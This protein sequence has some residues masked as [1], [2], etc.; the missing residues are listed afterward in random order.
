MK[1]DGK[2]VGFF[3]DALFGIQHAISAEHHAK[4]SFSS[5]GK[6]LWMDV[7]KIVREMRS[8]YLYRIVKEGNAQCYCV[9]K[10][11]LAFVQ[12]LKE[13]GDRYT[14]SGEVDLSKECFNDSQTI[15]KIVMIINDVDKNQGGKK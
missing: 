9:T 8:K 4:E 6:K 5:T 1:E 7:N 2:D 3:E 13:M 11:L 15:E 14:E 12:S 10:H